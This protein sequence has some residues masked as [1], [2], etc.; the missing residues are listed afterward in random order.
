MANQVMAE[1]AMDL[2]NWQSLSKFLAEH[3]NFK[4]NTLRWAI[5]QKHKN[6]LA[7]HVRK[8]G[9]EVYLNVPGFTKWFH[10]VTQ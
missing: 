8:F 6:G 10:G 4:E 5:R 2:N 9:K 7:P 3:Q 1:E